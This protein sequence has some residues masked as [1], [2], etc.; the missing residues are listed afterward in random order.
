MPTGTTNYVM[1]TSRGARRRNR[2]VQSI[3]LLNPAVSDIL[4][5]GHFGAGTASDILAIP[6][7]ENQA[8]FAFWLRG[9]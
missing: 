9:E 3:A 8:M 5:A 4:P 6:G 7:T 1:Y 2:T